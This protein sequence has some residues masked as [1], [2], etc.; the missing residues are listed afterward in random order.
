MTG[1]DFRQARLA[2]GL[3][4]TELANLMGVAQP[5]IARLEAGQTVT[6][7]TAAFIELLLWIHQRGLLRAYR[8]TI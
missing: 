6:A 1:Q 7:T 4:Q 2:M 3:S 5:H 8:D